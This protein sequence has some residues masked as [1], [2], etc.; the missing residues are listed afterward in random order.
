[1]QIYFLFQ[2]YEKEKK[3]NVVLRRSKTTVKRLELEL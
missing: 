3:W 2:D 1:M